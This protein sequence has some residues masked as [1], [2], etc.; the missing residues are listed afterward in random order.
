ML[1]STIIVVYSR[2]VKY[3]RGESILLRHVARR[4]THKGEAVCS[5]GRHKSPRLQLINS[6][7]AHDDGM[8]PTSPDEESSKES[9]GEFFND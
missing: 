8:A 7:L 9:G 1:T 3:C 2:R 6:T 5:N 4:P